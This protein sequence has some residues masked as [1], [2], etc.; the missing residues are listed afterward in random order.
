MFN[1]ICNLSEKQT[2]HDILNNKQKL[3]T[4]ASRA[5]SLKCKANNKSFI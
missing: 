2:I 3:E 4:F 5:D 1:Y